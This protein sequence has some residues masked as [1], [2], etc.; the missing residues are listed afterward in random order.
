MLCR[1]TSAQ[2]ILEGDIKGCF[3]N[4]SH[5]W[6]TENIPMDKTILHKFLKSGYMEEKQLFPTKIWHRPRRKNFSCID[7]RYFRWLRKNDKDYILVQHKGDNRC[8]IR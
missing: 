7:E 6:L 3:D 4:I 5:Q 8:Q 1:R 2:W